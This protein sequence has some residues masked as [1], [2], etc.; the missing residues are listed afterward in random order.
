MRVDSTKSKR[1]QELR[2]H[3]REYIRLSSLASAEKRPLPNDAVDGVSIT[4][5]IVTYNAFSDL[6][7]LEA[8][9][10]ESIQS[11]EDIRIKIIDNGSS[12]GTVAYIES[13]ISK[14]SLPATLVSGSNVGFSVAANKC[15]EHAQSEFLLFLNPD[16]AIDME[17]IRTLVKTAK[18]SPD[19]HL[20]AAWEPNH[21]AHETRFFDGITGEIDWCAGTCLLVKNSA[22]KEVSGFDESFFLYGEDV[23][24]SFRLRAKGYRL[25][26][27]SSIR[28][29][30]Q[31]RTESRQPKLYTQLNVL[32][33]IKIRKK[34]AGTWSA[35]KGCGLAA[36]HCAV[37]GFRLNAISVFFKGVF[38]VIKTKPIAH[39]EHLIINGYDYGCEVDVGLVAAAYQDLTIE[40]GPL[41]SVIIRYT[42]ENL[43]LLATALIS[44][45]QQSYQSLEVC[46]VLKASRDVEMEAKEIIKDLG[47]ELDVSFHIDEKGSRSTALWKGLAQ[48]KGEFLQILDYDDF[49]YPL[50]IEDA[51]SA[52][53]VHPTADVFIQG[54]FEEEIGQDACIVREFMPDNKGQ[55]G[56]A[57]LDSQS[58][59]KFNEILNGRNLMPIQAVTFRK[60]LIS[61]I[62]FPS[63][64]WMEDWLLWRIVCHRGQI[65]LNWKPSSLFSTP[66]GDARLQRHQS[67]VTYAEAADKIT[68][69]FL[70]NIRL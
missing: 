56:T 36:V 68:R 23:D 12:D 33:N 22:F 18:A 52:L 50:H 69:D 40:D 15:A 7:T 10:S 9:L 66:T 53:G 37:N 35:L 67:F 11:K 42:G 16:C 59:S 6:G 25:K 51:I 44:V 32:A 63:I 49:L 46:L 57:F 3:R 5:C 45:Q 20:T 70:D 30:H 55:L 14:S 47:L 2:E 26:Q 34:F 8:L 65:H 1:L 43:D 28:V 62:I 64:D 31:S 48:A 13:L 17:T 58:H 39:V 38:C 24:L 21:R 61:D 41:V 4:I 29:A 54:S 60:S 27:I 19:Y